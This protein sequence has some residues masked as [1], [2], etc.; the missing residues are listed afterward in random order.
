MTRLVRRA[1]NAVSL[2]Q[3]V[4]WHWAL[5][6]AKHVVPLEHLVRSMW[7]RARPAR[8][9]DDRDRMIGLINR[10]GRLAGTPDRDCLQRSLLV[11]RALAACGEAPAMTVGFR[12]LDGRVVGHAWVVTASGVVGEDAAALAEFVPAMVIDTSGLVTDDRA[13]R[14]SDDRR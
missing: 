2:A 6:A 7:R 14:A 5:A 13:T 11:G 1:T 4:G 8:V 9:A 10:A 12:R 3:L